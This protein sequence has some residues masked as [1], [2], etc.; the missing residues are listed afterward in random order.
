MHISPT[1]EPLCYCRTAQLGT[2]TAAHARARSD[3]KL[4][5]LIMWINK[6]GMKRNDVVTPH[7]MV[8]GT[9]PIKFL[10]LT[11]ADDSVKCVQHLVHLG[12]AT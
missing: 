5:G 3:A 6:R 12:R 8:W 10:Y 7:Y 9:V 2:V 4:S 1:S 11:D